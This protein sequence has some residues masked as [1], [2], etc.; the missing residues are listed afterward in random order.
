MVAAGA[1]GIGG[2]ISVRLSVEKG[3]VEG[4]AITSSRPEK[5]ARIFVGR[6]PEETTRTLGMLYSLCGRAQ[7]IASLIA[8][9]DALGLQVSQ[10][11]MA[12]RDILRQ[13]EML[14][15]TAM[16]ICLDWPGLLELDEMPGL[17]KSCLEAEALLENHLFGHG[18]WNKPG[19]NGLA[20]D[21]AGVTSVI[22]N[23]QMNTKVILKSD[24]LATDLR[25]VLTERN[26][27]G[28][29]AMSGEE[30]REDG[31]MKRQRN[32]VLVSEACRVHGVGLRAR[33][34]ARLAELSSLPAQ[35]LV[36]AG[37]LG[38]ADTVFGSP[39]SGGKGL[40]RVETVRGP[41]THTVEIEN[42]FIKSYEIH[43]PTDNNFSPEGPVVLGL[44]GV[45]SSDVQDLA[46]AAKL[47]ITAIDPCVLC[48]LEIEHA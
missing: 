43:A 36:A 9:E 5:T 13:A 48:T 31:A 44:K 38:S 18:N 35:M 15:Q 4:V 16:R 24:G 37:K 46:R 39:A 21:I 28:F 40:S 17:V 2:D 19:E 30:K 25:N 1:K 42:G 7:T 14:S 22:E 45:E 47:H 32:D 34:E 27:D 29:G 26:L 23:L 3:V 6:S 11:R 10:E 8:V 33:L 12:A 41:L 20:P